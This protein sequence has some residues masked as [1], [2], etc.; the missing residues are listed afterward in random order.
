M[1]LA[2]TA[3]SSV[4]KPIFGIHA[5]EISAMGAQFAKEG[6][7]GRSHALADDGDPSRGTQAGSGGAADLQTARVFHRRL[8]KGIQLMGGSR[9]APITVQRKWAGELTQ[10]KFFELRGLA[11]LGESLKPFFQ[12]LRGQRIQIR[13]FLLDGRALGRKL[14]IVVDD[15]AQ[16]ARHKGQRQ[17]LQGRNVVRDQLSGL[18]RI[19]IEL[20]RLEIAVEA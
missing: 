5:A 11:D 2:A 7:L 17:L 19:A 8:A 4:S 12:L 15:L 10:S 18:G 20:L 9:D 14:E 13:Q 6:F 3:F 16:Q 1:A